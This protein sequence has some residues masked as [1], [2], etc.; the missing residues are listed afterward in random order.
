MILNPDDFKK[1]VEQ[2]EEYIDVAKLLINNKNW[3][4]IGEG[5][6]YE[7]TKILDLLDKIKKVSAV[8]Q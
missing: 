1:I 8:K 6:D 2:C 7:N 3:S 4:H 5:K